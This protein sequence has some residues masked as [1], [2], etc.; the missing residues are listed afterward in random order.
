MAV[1]VLAILATFVGGTTLMRVC[2][3]RGWGLVPLGFIAGTALYIAVGLVQ[4]V[5]PFPTTPVWTMLVTGIVPLAVWLTL[6]LR[7][8]DV[9]VPW[10][11]AI[12]SL[13]GI[14]GLT[15]VLRSANMLAWHVDS[16]DYLGMGAGLAQGHFEE[17]TPERLLTTRMIG[18]PL[19]HAPASLTDDFYLRSAV[20]LLAAATFAAIVWFFHRGTSHLVDRRTVTILTVVGLAFLITSNRIV[21]HVFYV[22][23]HL[24]AGSFVLVISAGAWLLATRRNQVEVRTLQAAILLVIPA[25]VV[26][27]PEGAVMA[28]VALL[29]L[30]ISRHV[31]VRMRSAALATLGGSMVVWFGYVLWLV[32]VTDREPESTTL[33]MLAIGVAFCIAAALFPV[34]PALRQGFDVVGRT[35]LLGAAEIFLWAS[36]VPFT[37]RDPDLMWRSIS[38]TA[39]N[40]VV[41]GWGVTVLALGAFAVLAAF[42]LRNHWTSY[43]RFPVTTFL[44]LVFLLAFLRDGG[45]RVGATDSLNR[46]WIQIIPLAV[47]YVMAAIALDRVD[48]PS[49]GADAIEDQATQ[50]PG[51]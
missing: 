25:L 10:R 43:L 13:A 15:V 30:L 22:N 16:H 21:H 27:R 1:E 47:L 19:I 17:S 11:A 49:T 35:R 46:M 5:G 3:L 12:G 20:P 48:R 6:V 37:V 40:Q 23:G 8:R 50:P 14:V 36:L 51:R 39:K 32:T 9:A 4:V 7:K 41:G 34:V 18:I 42:M 24:M 44:P 45:Y 28:A 2:G 31:S 29:P 33:E 26:T 38:A